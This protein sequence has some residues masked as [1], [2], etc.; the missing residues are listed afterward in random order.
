MTV[1]KNGVFDVAVIG[2]GVV[3]SAL[4]RELSHYRIRLVLLERE[5]D[6]SMGASRANSAIVHAGYDPPFGTKMA[7]L[8]LA[9][10]RM[11]PRLAEELSVPYKN[12]GSLICALSEEDRPKLTSLLENGQKIGVPG[13]EILSAE[14]VRNLEPNIAPGVAGALFAPTGGIVGSY[15]LTTALAENGVV[16]GGTVLLNFCVETVRLITEENGTYFE[17]LS[18]SGKKIGARYVVNAAGIYS[19]LVHGLIEP[20]R[21]EIKPRKGEYFLFDKLQ[22]N[23]VARTLFVCPGK[24]GKG[25]L[26]SPTVHGNLIAGP[27]AQDGVS[28]NDTATTAGGLDFV[29]KNAALLTE[30]ISFRETIRTFAGLRAVSTEKDFI[31]ERL[32]NFPNWIDLAGIKSPGLTSAPAIAEEARD[33]L[34]D[35]GLE[36]VEKPNFNPNRREIRFMSLS[37]EEK[38]RLIAQDPKFGR[39][40]CRC[41][42]ITE[43]EIVEAVNRPLGATTIDGVKRRCRPGCGRCQGGFCSPRVL[44]ILARELGENRRC[45]EQDRTGSSILIDRTK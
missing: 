28:R 38:Q 29:R 34:A 39:I 33:L 19:D 40:I 43:G 24:M 26:V 6:V 31:I 15:E 8:N 41:E 13:L 10:N 20:P 7:R 37:A 5:N 12:N 30:K 44:E 27:D 23:L 17:I 21:F 25:V 3:G 9:G 18:E 1:E 2:G 22:G 32:P 16:N 14:Q 4:F 36:L 11:M 45:V 35:A 42:S